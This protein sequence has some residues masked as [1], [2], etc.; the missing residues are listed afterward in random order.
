MESGTK[1]RILYL[2]QHLLQYTD[3]DHPESTVELRKMLQNEHG[4]KVS[5][6]TISDDLTMLSNC[7]L[8]IE[9]I[10]STQRQVLL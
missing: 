7:D 5:R 9:V 8:K 1:L 3:P 4:I 10:H 6:N 2:Y